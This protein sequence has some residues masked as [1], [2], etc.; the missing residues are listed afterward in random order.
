VNKSKCCWSNYRRQGQN[1]DFYYNVK[2]FMDKY[3]LAGGE[4]E[5]RADRADS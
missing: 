5:S 3:K 1:K 2:T 4:E